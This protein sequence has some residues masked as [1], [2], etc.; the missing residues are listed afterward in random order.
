[1]DAELQQL[2]VEMTVEYLSVISHGGVVPAGLRLHPGLII[3]GVVCLVYLM[4]KRFVVYENK[5]YYENKCNQHTTS[6][7]FSH[8]LSTVNRR[9]PKWASFGS[10][11]VSA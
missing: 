5:K 7:E 4:D 1:M 6:S 3:P 10:N 8:P 2:I 11:R 9:P